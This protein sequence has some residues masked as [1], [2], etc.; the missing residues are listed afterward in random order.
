MAAKKISFYFVLYLVVLVELLAVIIERDNSELELKARLKEF[1]T[2]QDSVISSY[3]KPVLLSVQEVTNWLIIGRDSLHIL[4]SV[5][6]LQTPEE[7]AGVRYFFIDDKTNSI[8]SLDLSIIT[9]KKTGNGH[10]YFKPKNAG[11]FDFNV[12]CLVRRKLPKYLPAIILEGIIREIG[13]EFTVVSDT[14]GFK[15]NA[16]ALKK[17]FDQPGRS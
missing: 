3:S 14:V 8:R 12:F 17:D 13:S 4:I 9:D 5:S 7:K 10:F 1:E 16:T 11:T 2:I 6:N 15:V